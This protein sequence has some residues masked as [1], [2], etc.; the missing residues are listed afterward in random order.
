M[1]RW[2]DL[3]S[4]T[5]TTPTQEMRQAMANAEV[6][7]DVFSDDPTLNELERLAAEM[8]G[9]EAAVFVPSGTMSNQLALF[10]HCQK[11]D[12]VILDQNAHIVQ[13][14]SGASAVIAGVQLYTLKGQ[15]GIWDLTE[16]ER[17]IKV[18]TVSTTRTKLI[19]LE[20]PIGGATVPLAYLNAVKEIA[21]RHHLPIHLDG[22]RIF[23][24]ATAMKIDVKAI[25]AVADSISVCLSKG[26]AAPVGTVLVGSKAF[27][28]E[29]RWKRKL[30]GGGM[31]QAGILGAAGIIALTKMTKRLEED[32]QNATYLANRLLEIKGVVIDETQRDINMVFFDLPDV[33]KYRLDEYLLTKDIKILPYEQGFRFVTHYQIHPVDIDYVIDVLKEYFHHA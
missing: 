16:L 30:M 28:E 13:H 4:D 2:I 32:H 11:G 19:C 23:N 8:F 33:K 7:D 3:R 1:K 12:E 9:K 21:H 31:R 20:T 15:N 17:A 10:T 6:G 26:L 5:V 22:A 29:A 27:I 14:E 25:A 18:K 24:A